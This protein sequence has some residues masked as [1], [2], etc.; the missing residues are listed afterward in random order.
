MVKKTAPEKTKILFNMAW[1]AEPYSNRLEITEWGGNK[2]LLFK[3]M[4]EITS[5][6]VEK[7]CGIDFVC[8]TGTAIMNACETEIRDALYRDG[9]H[10]SYD[11]GRFIA[12]LTFFAKLTN[13]DIE[14]VPL[15]FDNL[16]EREMKIAIESVKNAI[17]NPYTIIKSN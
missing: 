1:V 7:S 8:P 10:L 14:S 5:E 4:C 16:S 6:F 15:S 3:R 12:A 13:A 17:K 2:E 11:I 9:F